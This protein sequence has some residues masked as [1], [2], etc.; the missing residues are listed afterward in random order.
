MGVS[1]FPSIRQYKIKESLGKGQF[2]D[3]YKVLNTNDKKYIV[4]N[5]Y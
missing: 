5:Q 3:V 4:W 1:N 2:G